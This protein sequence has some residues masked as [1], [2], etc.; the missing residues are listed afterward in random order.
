[1]KTREIALIGLFA[2]LLCVSAWIRV[3]LGPIVLTFQLAVVALI[4]MMLPPLPAFLSVAAYLVLGLAG[5]PV[6]AAGGGLGYVLHPTFGYLA[7][8]ALGAPLGAWYLRKRELRFT[9][10]FLAGS[11]VIVVSYVCGIG[12]MW[13]LGQF[14]AGLSAS[15]AT[16]LSMTLGMLYVKD[17]ILV[18]LLASVAPRLRK[19][20]VVSE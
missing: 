7:G 10:T 8:F 5:L 16:I 13:A 19:Y 2:A 6:F 1:M 9:T 15:L 20:V 4:A 12:Y 3:P 18:A 14:I 11:I 17:V